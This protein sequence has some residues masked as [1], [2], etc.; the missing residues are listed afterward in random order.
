L[1]YIP[2]YF[3]SIKGTS[4]ITSGVYQ[5][6]FIAFFALGSVASGAI[7]GATRLLQP[8]QLVAAFITTLG[9]ALIYNL[10]VNSSKAWYI[11]AQIPLGLGLG[12]GNQVSVTALQGFLKPEYTAAAMGGLFGKHATYLEA[13]RAHEL[14]NSMPIYQWCLLQYGG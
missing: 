11:G 2:I 9:T 13:N 12:L 10:D 1:F 3:Q 6:P 4:A 5:I 7:V 14:W 8:V